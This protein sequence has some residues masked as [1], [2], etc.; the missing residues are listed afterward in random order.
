MFHLFYIADAVLPYIAKYK[1][2][3]TPKRRRS[4]NSSAVILPVLSA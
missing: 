4:K 2:P 3:Y 1:I